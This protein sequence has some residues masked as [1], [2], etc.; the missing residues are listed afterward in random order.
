MK[1]DKDPTANL[2]SKVISHLKSLKDQNHIPIELYRHLYPTSTET[3]KFYCLP[4]VHKPQ[5]PLRPIVA[6]RNSMTYNLAKFIAKVLRP[7]VGKSE[8]HLKNSQDLV[9]KLRGV[10]LSNNQS[11]IS[12]DVTS[13]FTNVPVDESVSIIRNKLSEDATLKDRTSLSADQIA[14][15]LSLCLK[16]TYFVYQGQFFKQVEGAAMGSP[17]SPI[18]AD[19]FMEHFEET[20]LSRFHTPPAFWGRYVD[21]TIV[22]LN[23]DHITEFTNHLNSIHNAIKFTYES[24]NNASLPMLDTLVI[25]KEDGTL[26]FKVYRKSTHT[27]HYLQF[28]S[29]QPSEH[30]LGVVRTLRH[31]ANTIITEETDKQEEMEHLKKVLS[32]S[33]YPKWSWNAK[34][35]RKI[36]QDER[37]RST[38]PP[39]GHVTL[40]YVG[41][42]TESI[43][44]KFRKAGVAA[45]V[46]PHTTIR[47]LLVAP[48]DK[49][50]PADKC[51]VVYS[52][53]CDQ[54]HASYVGETERQLRKRIA[55]H[56]R[57]SSP[58][59]QHLAETGHEA[60]DTS[61]FK[62]VDRD[63]NWFTRGVREA[64]HIQA[65][66]PNLNRDHGRHHLPVIYS[67]LIQS[68]DTIPSVVVTLSHD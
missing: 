67:S 57:Q 17:V 2:K 34:G 54:C 48:K 39:K 15:L 19:L 58:I 66:G 62:V 16:T 43:C 60:I 36:N 41:G 13:L 20:A 56:H 51:G 28:S 4:K 53:Q 63:S 33:G 7:L 12:Y 22:I 46:R 14:D 23:S 47:S 3:P 59:G 24:E 45:H 25:R 10:T 30:K 11:L 38:N 44:R 8:R 21:D 50:C 61:S 64:L 40:P 5:V 49:T 26:K 1:L 42:I 6:S 37:T 55:E 52:F 68:C 18:V 9:N 32:I 27:D 65:M 31:R 29:H 35:S